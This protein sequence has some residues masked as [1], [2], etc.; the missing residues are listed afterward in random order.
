MKKYKLDM[1]ANP[2]ETGYRD[3]IEIDYE[4]MV[5]QFGIGTNDGCKVSAE[6]RFVD[7]QG[8]IYTVYDFKQTSLYSPDKPSVEAFRSKPQIYHIG[9]K[10]NAKDFKAWLQNKLKGD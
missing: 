4:K 3:T 6:W 1:D 7:N 5:S 8:R 9:A 10:D 2:S